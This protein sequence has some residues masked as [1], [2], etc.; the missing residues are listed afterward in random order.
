MRSCLLF[1]KKES[2]TDKLYA[3]MIV[4]IFRAFFLH[5]VP[6]SWQTA[7]RFS[8][9]TR[10]LFALTCTIAVPG[11]ISSQR[12]AGLHPWRSNC[13]LK[14][15]KKNVPD[16]KLLIKAWVNWKESIWKNVSSGFWQWY[17]SETFF[18]FFPWFRQIHL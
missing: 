18:Y 6:C 11:S 10:S 15:W 2:F 4:N 14:S 17:Y 16:K 13:E 12:I 5:K 8:W 7:E 1:W 3:A 9:K